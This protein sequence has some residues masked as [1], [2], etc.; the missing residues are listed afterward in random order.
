M[1]VAV[2]FLTLS[3]AAMPPMLGDAVIDPALQSLTGYA[4]WSDLISGLLVGLAC[5]GL[6]EF[7]IAACG[8]GISPGVVRYLTA[9]WTQVLLMLWLT[10]SASNY[11]VA[12]TPEI[13]TVGVG[14]YWLWLLHLP[15]GT[16]IAL[17][18]LTV[19]IVPRSRGRVRCAFTLTGIAAAAGFAYCT[20]SAAAVVVPGRNFFVRNQEVIGAVTGGVAVAAL[21]LAGLCGVVWSRRIRQRERT[22]GTNRRPVD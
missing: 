12:W 1:T 9:I 16:M 22:N 5:A 20:T 4:N 3:T 8:L 6:L 7:A 13:E 17:A 19:R 21:A 14:L 18:T 15:F 11:A 2:G 10:T